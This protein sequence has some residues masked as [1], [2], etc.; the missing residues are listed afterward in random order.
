MT[1]I[2]GELIVKKGFFT[3]ED[4]WQEYSLY[5][6]E[7]IVA[8]FRIGT[9]GLKNAE[10]CH[11]FLVNDNLGVAH[12][13]VITEIHKVG[14]E[15][16]DTWFF[17]ELVLKPLM[18]KFPDVWR[19][20]T[21]KH[22]IM[23]KIG[24]YNKLVFMDNNGNVQIYNAE[25][26]EQDL[27]CWFSNTD[28]KRAYAYSNY[29]YSNY[30]YGGSHYGDD[31]D[32]ENWGHNQAERF[33]WG[34]DNPWYSQKKNEVSVQNTVKQNGSIGKMCWVA[35]E[36]GTLVKHIV[37]GEKLIKVQDKS[38][39]SP[40]MCDNCNSFIHINELY[41]QMEDFNVCKF[42]YE[43]FAKYGM[44]STSVRK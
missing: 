34:A 12:N 24:S 22:L 32:A 17:N 1:A 2:D 9:H 30:A 6:L 40:A 37:D 33:A 26:G 25:K 13:G 39:I 35:G 36:N 15:N 16:S 14:S 38:A 11:P 20:K 5:E 7:N 21:I 43:D 3:F 10:N 29:A 41:Y 4:F 42:C 31:Y 18:S 23:K 44:E 27:G 19:H 8:H 28:Y